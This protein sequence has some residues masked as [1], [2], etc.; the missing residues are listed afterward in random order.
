MSKS[1]ARS[2]NRLLDSDQ[3]NI[4]KRKKKDKITLK[5]ANIDRVMVM[6]SDKIKKLLLLGSCALDDKTTKSVSCIQ[7]YQGHNQTIN[8]F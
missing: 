5:T 1:L 4:Q 6:D 2:A 8:S 7:A 3:N